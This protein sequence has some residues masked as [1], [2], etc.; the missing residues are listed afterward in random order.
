MLEWLAQFFQQEMPEGG[1]L[2]S[3][4][5]HTSKSAVKARSSIVSKIDQLM[6]E[7]WPEHTE[8][9]AAL[10]AG[11]LKAARK[12]FESRISQGFTLLETEIHLVQPALYQ[13]GREWQKNRVS[14]A[15]EHLATATAIT[16]MAQAFTAAELASSNDKKVICACVEGNQHAVGLRMVS[17]GFELK[18]WEVIF[19]GP[20]V[21]TRDLIEHVKQ[22]NPELVCLSV[23][24]P[25]HLAVAKE[26]ISGVRVAMGEKTPALMLGGLAIN[27]FTTLAKLSG[28]DATAPDAE[29]VIAETNKNGL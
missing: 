8:L 7:A 17:D 2:I 13:V 4:A 20:N 22:S 21:P 14:V 15:Q 1:V 23:S 12:V 19:L 6:P 24:M 18:G 5:L 26:V 27:A 10:L 9:M 3:T 11:D 28:A 25:D 29:S 16:L